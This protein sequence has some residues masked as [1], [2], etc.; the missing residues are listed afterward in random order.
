M[1]QGWQ[2]YLVVFL[3]GALGSIARYA[4]SVWIAGKWSSGFP[5]GTLTVNALGCLLIGWLYGLTSPG[6]PFVVSPAVR[7]FA[8]IGICGGFTTM[9]SFTLQT[10]LLALDGQMRWALMNIGLSLVVCLIFTWIGMAIS[11]W[12][13]FR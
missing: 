2:I 11:P 6:G 7:A 8:M 9:S 4:L 5:W 3:G 13:K 1:L 12:P 10:I